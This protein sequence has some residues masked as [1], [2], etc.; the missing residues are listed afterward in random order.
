MSVSGWP[1]C[2]CIVAGGLICII[3]KQK[4][5]SSAKLQA[6]KFIFYADGGGGDV[7][8]GGYGFVAFGLRAVFPKYYPLT[9]KKKARVARAVIRMIRVSCGHDSPLFAT[10]LRRFAAVPPGWLR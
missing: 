5:A 8:R 9:G 6:W 7:T 3:Y 1:A 10:S 4:F 2:R